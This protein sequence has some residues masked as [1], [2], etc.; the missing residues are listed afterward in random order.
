M[1]FIFKSLG[2]HAGRYRIPGDN[3]S[4]FILSVSDVHVVGLNPQFKSGNSLSHC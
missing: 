3:S 4:P 2:F 1:F